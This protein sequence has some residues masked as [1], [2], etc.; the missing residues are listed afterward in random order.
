MLTFFPPSLVFKWSFGR[1]LWGL[2]ASTAWEY[3][4]V[5]RPPYE[6]ASAVLVLSTAEKLETN[7]RRSNPRNKMY[8]KICTAK[9]KRKQRKKPC[10]VPLNV[11]L[12]SEDVKIHK[13]HENSKNRTTIFPPSQN[14]RSLPTNLVPRVFV[15]LD[16]RV[17]LRETLG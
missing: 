2:T 7:I 13:S 14:S 16:Q 12:A 10:L 8:S 9:K 17:G 3:P 15:P 11:V 1:V 5:A 6:P 4:V